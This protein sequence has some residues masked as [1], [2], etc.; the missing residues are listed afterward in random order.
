MNPAANYR[1][2]YIERI[3]VRGAAVLGRIVR[4]VGARFG[5]TSLT[6]ALALAVCM[7]AVTAKAERRIALV[8]GNSGYVNVPRLENPRNDARLMAETLRALGL[9]LVEGA[10]H[11]DLDKPSFDKIVQAFGTQLQGADVGLFYYAGH[12]VQVRG[13]NY[14][15]PIDANPTKEADVDFQMLDSNL[16][17]RQMESA[18]TKLNL[19]ILD[20]CRNN[21]FGGRGLRAVNAGL[22]QMRA[23]EG[24][25]ISFATQP[26]AVAQDGVDGNSP[27]TKYLTQAM[28]KPGLDVFRT[29]N[30]VGLAV[31]RATGGAQ[32][33]WVSIS[34]INGEFYFAGA[35]RKD[36]SPTIDTSAE[37]WTAT[38]DTT[39]EAVLE[40]FIRQFGNT[41]YGS[42][43]R[44]RLNELRQNHDRGVKVAVAIVPPTTTPSRQASKALAPIEIKKT[45]FNGKPFVATTPSDPL[46]NKYR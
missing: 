27:Y 21:P 16:V 2:Q 35:L 23:P 3:P 13:A 26:G 6:G 40:D 39:S 19:V 31:T 12:G 17:L 1:D 36:V 15:V 34:P 29:F 45:F 43:A 9:E 4:I 37:A 30:E 38:K 24:T 33:P 41:V 20:A 5:H 8:V 7:S 10:A 42:L 32:Q 14:L 44:A 28:R 46:A 22:A 18:G 11:F 25:L